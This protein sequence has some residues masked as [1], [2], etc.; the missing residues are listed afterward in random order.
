MGFFFFFRVNFMHNAQIQNLI[1]DIELNTRELHYITN[2][3]RCNTDSLH[4][5]VHALLHD[6]DGL[7]KWTVQYYIGMRRILDGTRSSLDKKSDTLS[8]KSKTLDASYRALQVSDTADRDGVEKALQE[9]TKAVIDFFRA[10]RE[11]DRALQ[12]HDIAFTKHAKARE[13]HEKI[14]QIY[15]L[16]C[17]T[18][19][20]ITDLWEHTKRLSENTG[21]LKSQTL[22]LQSSTE[23]LLEGN[24]EL[25]DSE[26]LVNKCVLIEGAYNA[27]RQEFSTIIRRELP[28]IVL[29]GTMEEDE[30]NCSQTRAW[31]R[32]EYSKARTEY[33]KVH[34]SFHRINVERSTVQLGNLLAFQ[35]YNKALK[36]YKVIKSL[37]SGM[38]YE[39]N[40]DEDKGDC[41][42]C[43][44]KMESGEKLI[45]WTK[46]NHIFHSH[47]IL[48]WIP[49]KPSCPLCRE[50]LPE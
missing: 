44:S 13:E 18:Q 32:E 22:I 20:M 36:L 40:K 16:V 29:L 28:D 47:C 15:D 17:K 11:N 48:D 5:Q 39:E 6:K 9:N 33:E 31:V 12:E 42:I 45:K 46:C 49:E 41:C 8:D 7:V 3:M 1:R 27:L 50:P 43:M 34:I 23:S 2:E 26:L 38:Q 10:S 14:A 30:A 19:A 4:A 24:T 21:E 25:T 35:E 37:G